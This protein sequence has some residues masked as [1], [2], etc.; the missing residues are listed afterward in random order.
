MN[1]IL[2]VALRLLAA[3]L[4]LFAIIQAIAIVTVRFFWPQATTNE[5]SL[6]HFEIF[7]L[8][9]CGVL[10]LLTLLLIGWYLGKPVY[11]IMVWIRRLTSGQYELPERWDQIRSR[12]GGTLKIQYA[13]YREL[14]EHVGK[15]AA[16]LENN[17]KELQQSERAKQEWI[18]GISHDLKTPLTY[19]SG[20]S[21]ML[22]N[23]EYRWSDAERREFL[24]VIQQ[25]A[26]HLQELVLDLNESLQGQVPLK[27]EETDLVELVRRTVADVGSAPWAAGYPFGM[28][29]E[30]D[31]LIVCCDPKLLT[32]A[33][34]NLLVN[35]VVHNPEGTE[36]SVRISRLHDRSAEIRIEDNG[37]GFSAKPVP[38]GAAASS[39]RLGLGMS[40]ARQLIEA[41]GGDLSVISKP[42]EGTFLSIRLPPVED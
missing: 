4:L 2:R 24:S 33:V 6:A 12:K 11:F 23:P 38:S 26:A 9:L 35:A 5:I 36:I 8:A 27:K 20:Y 22:L 7:V 28:D 13:V 21:T 30:P 32:R 16:T 40:I 3:F 29:A 31:S 39:G 34:R 37:V 10:F 19:I 42:N 18:R 14:L 15:L 1:F 25:K 41:H 17:K